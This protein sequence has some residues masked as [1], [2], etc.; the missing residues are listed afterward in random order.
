M[1]HK[2]TITSLN[3]VGFI[4]SLHLCFLEYRWSAST[5]V[6]FIE[7]P[8]LKIAINNNEIIIEIRGH[9]ETKFLFRNKEAEELEVTVTANVI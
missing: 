3:R 6:I 1:P 2:F 9:E 8:D 7:M 4:L 5:D